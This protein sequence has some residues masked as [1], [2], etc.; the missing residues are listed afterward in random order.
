MEELYFLYLTAD[1]CAQFVSCYTG[2]LFIGSLRGVAVPCFFGT[3][4][5][6]CTSENTCLDICFQ[7]P[8][9]I[10]SYTVI[11]LTPRGMCKFAGSWARGQNYWQFMRRWSF[12]TG[13][14]RLC[15]C[16]YRPRQ[17][18]LLP[19]C[20]RHLWSQS[21]LLGVL[22]E[23]SFYQPQN[24]RLRLG[25]ETQQWGLKA[26]FNIAKSLLGVIYFP[27]TAPHQS[28]QSKRSLL[29]K[30]FPNVEF[31]EGN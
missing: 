1:F 17:C 16:F 19:G 4:S 27:S 22:G 31:V 8:G 26:T 5:T 20:N 12:P 9:L 28:L 30:I 13:S 15:S 23:A 2:L 25:S 11:Q 18:P 24:K 14:T 7:N 29:D 10:G 6:T 3:P 21:R